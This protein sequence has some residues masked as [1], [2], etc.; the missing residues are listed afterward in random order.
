MTSDSLENENFDVLVLGTGPVEA[1]VASELS[2]QGRKV[3]HIDRAPHYGGHHTSLTVS[4]LLDWAASTRD[5]R[6]VP[7][8]EIHTATTTGEPVAAEQLQQTFADL[9]QND[10]AYAIE[11]APRLVRCRSKA[12]DTLLDAGVGD[13]MQFCGVDRNYTLGRDQPLQRVPESK[14][15]VF[16][17]TWLSFVE[18]RKLMRLLDALGGD[19]EEKLADVGDSDKSFAEWLSERPFALSGRLLDAVVYAVA[20]QGRHPLTAREGCDAV[21]RYIGAMGR[22]GRMAYLCALYGGGSEV[23]QAFCRLCAVSGGTYILNECPAIVSSPNGEGFD[24]SLRNGSAHV[25]SIVMDPTYAPE[26]TASQ[27][28]NTSVARALC[29]LDAAP[30]GDD[31]TAL[32]TFI[33][34][35]NAAVSLLYMTHATKAVPKG[36]SIVYAWIEGTLVDS[37]SLLA[38]AIDAIASKSDSNVCH[39]LLT[40]YFETCELVPPIESGVVYT[41]VS[42][43]DADFDAIIDAAQKAL[44]AI[45]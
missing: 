22:Y 18:K 9:I 17:A 34:D 8:V 42:M 24:V 12:I 38:E 16:A 4:A 11:L 19:D 36:Q 25:R 33:A 37:K 2:D 20:R 7:C 5:R 41:K 39:P 32:L 1:L 45:P 44:S 27:D 35:G 10:R 6:Q 29:I 15:D 30:L 28:S 13:Y 21:R 40:A 43:V 3:L 14:E 26:A 31:S 23:A